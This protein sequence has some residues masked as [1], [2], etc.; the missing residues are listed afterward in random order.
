LCSSGANANA[1]NAPES[2][3]EKGL[4]VEPIGQA[5]TVVHDPAE[6]HRRQTVPAK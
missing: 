1:N 4:R 5:G 6:A 2:G 3:A